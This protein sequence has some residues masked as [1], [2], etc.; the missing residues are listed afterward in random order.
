MNAITYKE[1]FPLLKENKIWLGNN[2]KVNGGAMFFEIPEDIANLEQ[3]REVKTD[4]SGKKVYVTRV[5]GVRWFTN[6]D[7]GRR[8]EPLQLMTMEGNKRYNK[9]VQK[10]PNCY[11]KYDNYDAIDISVVDEKGNRRGSVNYIPIDYD[12]VMGVPITF[13]HKYNPDQFEIVGVVSAPKNPGSLNLGK[14]YSK[15][16]GYKQNGQKNGRT[17]STFGRNAVLL[18]DDGKHDYY[19]K[20]GVRVHSASA[21]IFIRN[22]HPEERSNPMMDINL[23]EIT[24]RDLFDKYYEDDENGIV[25]GYHGQL[26]MRPV[27]QLVNIDFSIIT[28][29][30][31]LTKFR[32]ML[33]TFNEYSIRYS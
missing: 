8:H 26:N 2:Y 20:D 16:I 7:H 19:E 17:G 1:V 23:H 6:L 21:R 28:N 13:L 29:A 32:T 25:T 24:I 15:F 10:N 27:Y 12:G 30:L 3:V 11:K 31:Q 5:Q 4:E 9:K 14:D 22:K 33:L 18:G